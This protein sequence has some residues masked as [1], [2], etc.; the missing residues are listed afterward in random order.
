MY[1]QLLSSRNA[2]VV[3]LFDSIVT[4]NV[5]LMFQNLQ[6]VAH[7]TWSLLMIGNTFVLSGL[8]H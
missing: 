8:S 1:L 7:Q 3:V 5:F 2:L 4:T 6:S